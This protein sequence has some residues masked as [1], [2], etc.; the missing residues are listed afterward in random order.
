[1]AS[2]E[3]QRVKSL[4]EMQEMW[5][6]SL[7]WEDPL[8]KSMAAHPRPFWG[9]VERLT[10]GSVPTLECSVKA[11][12]LSVLFL[13]QILSACP[14]K[15]SLDTWKKLVRLH[16]LRKLC[17]KINLKNFI[18]FSAIVSVTVIIYWVFGK[19]FTPQP[20]CIL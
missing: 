16:D 12:S 17:C 7:G 10:R 6:R 20:N 11:E 3:A 14:H 9:R 8:E 19:S 4:P 15:N 13:S 1:M 2:L 18:H 5:V